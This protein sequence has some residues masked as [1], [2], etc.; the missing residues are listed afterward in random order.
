MNNIVHALKDKIISE[1]KK[2]PRIYKVR[3]KQPGLP[4]GT[5]IHTGAPKVEKITIDVTSYSEETLEEKFF[6]KIEEVFSYKNS[7]NVSW[8]NIIG[9][10]DTELLEKL[11]NHFGIHPLAL[12]DVLNTDQ[13]PKVDDYESTLYCVLKSI[14]LD[15][16]AQ[17]ITAE[18]V[19]IVFGKSWVVSFQERMPDC[20][21]PVR[22]RI[23]KGKGRIR[24]GGSDY[25]LYALI[26][27]VVDNYF[28]VL[29]KIGEAIELL[30]N[31]L[32]TN[33]GTESLNT[34]YK[35]RRELL[36]LRKSVWPLREV[37][38]WLQR[39]ETELIKEETQIYIRDV[40]DHAIQV[41]DTVETYREMISGMLDTY[42]SSV[43]NRM[44]EVMKVLTIIA[45]IF[46]PLTFIAGVYG[47]NF[48]N[49][50]ELRWTW[51]YPWGFWGIILIIGGLMFLFFKRKKW[52]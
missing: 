23:R 22:E 43:S 42:L 49:F 3:K 51:I 40:Y 31:E 5:L 7:E 11:G 48:M 19:S 21:E 35:L 18:Q 36:F 46:I 17:E 52:L 10:H 47:M 2:I 13:R 39:E 26:D 33:P 1:G 28:S 9:L 34:I 27:M 29:E 12:E 38:S 6:E 44:N 20:F 32:V 8:I 25:L 4:P 41:I 14:G 16:D 37:L 50:P 45:T 15:E 30:E 24:K